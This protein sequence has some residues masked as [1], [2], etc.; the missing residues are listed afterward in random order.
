MRVTPLILFDITG[1]RPDGAL[2]VNNRVYYNHAF[3]MC[4]IGA[5][6]EVLTQGGPFVIKIKGI[7]MHKTSWIEPGEQERREYAQ[8]YVLD[9]QRACDTRLSNFPRLDPVLTEELESDLRQNHR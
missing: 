5:K 6:Q 4:S 8:I 7:V 3:A 1:S 2:F 9:P